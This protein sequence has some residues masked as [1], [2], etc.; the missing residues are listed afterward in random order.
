MPPQVSIVALLYTCTSFSIFH[1]ILILC[2]Y[3]RNYGNI[4]PRQLFLFSFCSHRS[5]AHYSWTL[6]VCSLYRRYLKTDRL[7]GRIV[8]SVMQYFKFGLGMIHELYVKALLSNVQKFMYME[9][10]WRVFMYDSQCVGQER[11]GMLDEFQSQLRL[12]R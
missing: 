10:D 5:S 12:Q 9:V 8:S 4:Q 6:S 1:M 3:F 2:M 11:R 7:E